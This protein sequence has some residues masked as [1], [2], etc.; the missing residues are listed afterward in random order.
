MNIEFGEKFAD[1]KKAREEDYNFL[2]ETIEDLVIFLI[3]E[4]NEL[5][6]QKVLSSIKSCG[7]N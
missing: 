2:F 5:K 1:V 6:Y 4:E 7:P 3:D